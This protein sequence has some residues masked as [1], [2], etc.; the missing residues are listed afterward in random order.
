MADPL[1][2]T[3]VGST[4]VVEGI[5]FLYGQMTEVMKRLAAKRDKP[6]EPATLPEPVA[7]PTV[8]AQEGETRQANLVTAEQLEDEMFQLHGDLA[9]YAEGL[10]KPKE[11]D[12]LVLEQLEALRKVMEAVY[13]NHITFK[14]EKLPTSEGPNVNAELKNKEVKGYVAGVRIKKMNAG[15]VSAKLDI[16]KVEAGGTAIGVEIDEL[17]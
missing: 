11:G 17:G 15:N 10:R 13:A 16:D 5:K 6:A 1:T 9:A 2:W 8:F 4:V 12:P 7:L 14:G 3:V